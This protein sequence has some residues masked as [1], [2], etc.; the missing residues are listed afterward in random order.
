MVVY[1]EKQ[2]FSRKKTGNSNSHGLNKLSS[3]NILWKL[4]VSLSQTHFTITIEFIIIVTLVPFIKMK[5][6]KHNYGCSNTNLKFGNVLN[7]NIPTS[8]NQKYL[9]IQKQLH[10]PNVPL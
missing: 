5:C 3:Y 9:I 10:F 2:H 6:Y 1:L 4:L 7:E 8:V